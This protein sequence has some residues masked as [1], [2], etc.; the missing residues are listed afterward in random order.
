M[1]TRRYREKHVKNLFVGECREND[2]G[3]RSRSKESSSEK[4]LSPIECDDE[5]AERIGE[6]AQ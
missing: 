3:E 1:Q 4:E 6:K 2:F 5:H